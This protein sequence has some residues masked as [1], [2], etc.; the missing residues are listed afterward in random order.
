MITVM[1]VSSGFGGGGSKWWL[2]RVSDD[3]VEGECE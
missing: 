2:L 1:K 3:C